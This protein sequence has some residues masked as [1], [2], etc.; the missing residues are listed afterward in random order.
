MCSPLRLVPRVGRSSSPESTAK[1]LSWVCDEYSGRGTRT[2]EHQPNRH[3]VNEAGD[4]Q[5]QTT[6]SH[7]ARSVC[8]NRMRSAC[9]CTIVFL[10]TAFAPSLFATPFACGQ[11]AACEW[12][13]DD[14]FRGAFILLHLGPVNTTGD[15]LAGQNHSFTSPSGFWTVVFDSISQFDLDS[16]ELM[17]QVET[18]GFMQHVMRPPGDE[19]AADPPLGPKLSFDL[20]IS[21][22]G[23]DKTSGR[24]DHAHEE[25]YLALLEGTGAS[26]ILSYNF[27]VKARHTEF[28]F[29]P[30]PPSVPEP[31]TWLLFSTGLAGLLASSRRRR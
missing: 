7:H 21:G 27:G 9:C 20:L 24:E 11:G 12:I 30:P 16:F 25:T 23:T 22:E 17:D 31:A 3:W 15:L 10:L 4:R 28:F 18:E 6:R 5:S 14:A 19:H 26:A 29:E 13:E 1:T 2:R 8:L